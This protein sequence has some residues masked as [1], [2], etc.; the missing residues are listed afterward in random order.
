MVNP[1]A[2][3][4]PEWGWPVIKDVARRNG[5]ES[6]IQ[7]IRKLG[8]DIFGH[9]EGLIRFLEYDNS[10][11]TPA[12][13]PSPP[14]WFDNETGEHVRDLSFYST[15]IKL[16]RKENERYGDEDGILDNQYLAQ[17][18]HGQSELKIQQILD[19]AFDVESEIDWVE[20]FGWPVEICLSLVNSYLDRSKNINILENPDKVI[21]FSD[22]MIRLFWQA[23][24]PEFEQNEDNWDKV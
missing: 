3:Q 8:E 11:L 9:V 21:S 17:I 23:K 4:D 13:R 7:H 10:P 5:K 14:P 19:Q 6:I 12:S 24:R 16:Q 20:E 15:L 2:V 22:Y 1:D 18:K